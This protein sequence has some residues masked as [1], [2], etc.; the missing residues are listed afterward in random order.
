MA[1]AGLEGGAAVGAG[2]AVGIELAAGGVSNMLRAVY[3]TLF[4]AGEEPS[5]WLRELFGME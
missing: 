5:D 4:F 1:V 2:R 3:T